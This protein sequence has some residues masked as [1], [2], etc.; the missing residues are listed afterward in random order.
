MSILKKQYDIDLNLG[1]LY[2]V[3]V[4]KWGFIG[5][6][7]ESQSSYGPTGNWWVVQDAISK[8]YS[9]SEIRDTIHNIVDPMIISHTIVV[10]EIETYK[11]QMGCVYRAEIYRIPKDNIAMPEK[12]GII[13]IYK[14]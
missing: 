13:N 11:E 7:S 9:T 4:L 1:T 12:L 14:Q 10:N 3:E 6:F 8:L 5:K 2:R